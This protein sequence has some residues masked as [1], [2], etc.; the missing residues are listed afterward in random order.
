MPL[1]N[2]LQPV[3]D[4]YYF[5]YFLGIA[6]T[7]QQSK[8]YK[9]EGYSWVM[10]G[11]VKF[12]QYISE[13]NCGYNSLNV[14][15]STRVHCDFHLDMT[16]CQGHDKCKGKW[17]Q[18]IVYCKRGYFRWGK[19]SWKCCQDISRGGNFHDTTPI[20]FMK[21]YGFQFPRLQ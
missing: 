15:F 9:N 2:L 1:W 13:K 18:S 5:S 14:M 4:M 19:I 16:L 12:I 7:V 6:A 8:N 10:E 17:Q 3:W 21:A 11:N 20:Y